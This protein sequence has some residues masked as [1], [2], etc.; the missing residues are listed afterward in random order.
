MRRGEVK[1][2]VSDPSCLLY[3]SHDPYLSLLFSRGLR[4][5]A[6]VTVI[7]CRRKKTLKSR[8]VLNSSSHYF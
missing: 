4:L 8:T 1:S 6:T 7:P 3:T 2:H 5:K